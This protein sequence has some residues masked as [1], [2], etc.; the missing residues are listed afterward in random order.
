MNANIRK[1]YY[2]NRYYLEV[3]LNPSKLS[4]K[5]KNSSQALHY[6]VAV[7]RTILSRNYHS[8]TEK[9]LFKALSFTIYIQRS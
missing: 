2:I 7:K 8:G 6:P 1:Y 5:D 4:I 3:Y 9:Q